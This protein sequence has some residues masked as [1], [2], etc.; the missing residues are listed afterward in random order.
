MI[1]ANNII[2][3]EKIPNYFYQF[4]AA[5][6][7]QPQNF[8]SLVAELWEIFKAT[9]VA[10]LIMQLE[11]ENQ[12]VK[13]IFRSMIIK[14]GIHDLILESASTVLKNGV[15]I[16]EG[17]EGSIGRFHERWIESLNPFLSFDW[18]FGQEWICESVCKNSFLKILLNL[19][20][21]I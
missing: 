18:N 7:K 2:I 20:K 3:L 6:R 16:E 21:S 9:Y 17:T 4:E 15:Q 12:D 14:F 10:F 11:Y 5:A 8:L 19:F 1:N 13:E